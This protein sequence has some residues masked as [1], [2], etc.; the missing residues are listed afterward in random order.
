[1]HLVPADLPLPLVAWSQRFNL[2]LLSC[3]RTVRFPT[4][5]DDRSIP[6]GGPAPGR[7]D[8]SDMGQKPVAS[9]F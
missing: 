8:G 1:M 7:L 2:F 3:F 5:S 6:A 4:S 9:S